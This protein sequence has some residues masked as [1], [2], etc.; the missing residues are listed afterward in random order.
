MENEEK[1][2]VAMFLNSA[3]DCITDYK[4]DITSNFENVYDDVAHAK[5]SLDEAM[6]IMNDV[7]ER[8]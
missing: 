4:N 2:Q 3:I 8:I 1:K 6:Q 7:L 5:E